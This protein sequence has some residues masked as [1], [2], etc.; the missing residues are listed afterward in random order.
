MHDLKAGVRNILPLA[1][2]TNM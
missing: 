1:N 2:V